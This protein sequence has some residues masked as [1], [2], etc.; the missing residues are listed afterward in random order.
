[1]DSLILIIFVCIALPLLLSLGLVD[2]KAR[3][4]IG[5]IILGAFMCLFVS[6]VNSLI[7]EA[8][9]ES[10]Y[11]V[12]TNITPIT[13]EIVKALPVLLFA[14]L[15]SDRRD[16]LITLAM[17][18]GIGFA[19][20]ENILVFIQSGAEYGIFWAVRRVFGASLM[21]GLCTSM[22]GFGISFVRKHRKLF[23]T[24]TFA[25][26]VTAMAYHSVFNALVMSDYADFGFLLPVLTYVLIVFY[27]YKTRKRN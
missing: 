4:T 20:V 13:E 9:N 23:Y 15:I 22:V 10:S 1:M 17:A 6:S 8:V 2:N 26:L 25:L 11:Y 24:G 7:V 12:K 16:T 14:F 3:L 19:V 5:F 21:H 18:V 27:L